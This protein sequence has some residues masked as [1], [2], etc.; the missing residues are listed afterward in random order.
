[1]TQ[2]QQ[3]I[4]GA[5][6]AGQSLCALGA[7]YQ[8]HLG[9]RK[10]VVGGTVAVMTRVNLRTVKNLADKG[11]IKHQTRAVGGRTVSEYVLA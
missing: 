6:R 10:A 3:Q 9:E 5:L 7:G 1:V 11:L 8:I 4:L 2:L